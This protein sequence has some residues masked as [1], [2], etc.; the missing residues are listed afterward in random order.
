MVKGIFK[1]D[2][3]E[4]SWRNGMGVRAKEDCRAMIGNIAA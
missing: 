3:K 1:W 2:K 4:L